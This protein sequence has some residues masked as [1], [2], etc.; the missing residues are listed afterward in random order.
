MSTTTITLPGQITITI[1]ALGLDFQ[2]ECEH[3]YHG[4]GD[5]RH[6]GP[7]AWMQR[8][9]CP[10]CGE[11]LDALVCDRWRQTVSTWARTNYMRA[12]CPACLQSF[13]VNDV[14]FSFTRI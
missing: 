12:T 14:N 6:E 11:N 9:I 1:E 2:P 8:G 5:K 13:P 3:Q 7:A 4:R 10:S